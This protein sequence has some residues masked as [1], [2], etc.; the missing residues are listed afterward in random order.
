MG[1]GH[2]NVDN[3]TGTGN[4]VYGRS[5]N[6]RPRERQS[7]RQT[8]TISSRLY[9]AP[10]HAAHRDTINSWYEDRCE[11]SF[12][13]ETI[14]FGE[15]WAQTTINTALDLHEAPTQRKRQQQ[16]RTRQGLRVPRLLLDELVLLAVLLSLSLRV[17]PPLDLGTTRLHLDAGLPLQPPAT[18]NLY[19]NRED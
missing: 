5:N 18:T 19:A 12:V 2:D 4:D 13:R 7:Q 17:Y 10:G 15:A 6:E 3:D 1:H 14:R 11:R 8:N 9:R 16:Q